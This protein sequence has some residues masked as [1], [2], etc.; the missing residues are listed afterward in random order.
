MRYFYFLIIALFF[1]SCKQDVGKSAK[2]VPKPQVGL[3]TENAMVV[4]AREEA[5]KIGSDIMQ[6]GG[7]A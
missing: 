3:I 1:L 4:S 6:K 7:N 2:P 5:S